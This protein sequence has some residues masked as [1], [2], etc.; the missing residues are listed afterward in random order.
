MEVPITPPCL[1]ASVTHPGPPAPN[2]GKLAAVSSSRRAGTGTGSDAR[3]HDE[4]ER[5]GTVSTGPVSGESVRGRES[6]RGSGRET[7]S[8]TGSERGKDGGDRAQRTEN[9]TQR[10][11][12]ATVMTTNIALHAG[13]SPEDTKQMT[14]TQNPSDHR[15]QNTRRVDDDET[16]MMTVRNLWPGMK[17]PLKGTRG[18]LQYVLLLFTWCVHGSLHGFTWSGQD[19]ACFCQF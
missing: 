15:P 6:G 3:G 7:G 18:C 12:V 16:R 4:T 11:V 9:E 13:Q 5:A 17:H 10:A 19:S 8:E 1:A 14:Q 2:S